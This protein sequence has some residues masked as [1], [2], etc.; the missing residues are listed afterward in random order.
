[1]KTTLTY[2][3]DYKNKGRKEPDVTIELTDGESLGIAI[4]YDNGELQWFS[5]AEARMIAHAILG[6]VD[7]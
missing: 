5:M 7:P 4:P 1:M 6:M 2:T 3:T